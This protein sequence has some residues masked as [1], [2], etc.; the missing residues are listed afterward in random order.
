MDDPSLMAEGDEGEPQPKTAAE[1]AATSWR[2][3]RLLLVDRNFLIIFFFFSTVFSYVC[4]VPA[5]LPALM[6]DFNFTQVPGGDS[7]PQ[8]SG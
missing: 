3:C 8:S 7:M 2:A 1:F 6:Q 5:E 4:F